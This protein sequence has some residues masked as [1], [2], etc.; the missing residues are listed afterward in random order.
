MARTKQIT[1]TLLAVWLALGGSAAFAGEISTGEAEELV[2]A[3]QSEALVIV[4]DP[5]LSVEESKQ[6]FQGIVERYFD[7]PWMVRFLLGRY[8]RVATA[9]QRAEF[10]RL[11]QAL[12]VDSY[13]RNLVGSAT[14]FSVQVIGSRL[15]ANGRRAVVTTE[16]LD[17]ETDSTLI[18]WVVSKRGNTDPR[19]I[20][21]VFAGISFLA[22]KREEFRT[23]MR[24]HGGNI[25]AVLDELRAQVA[26]L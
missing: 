18:Q 25:E 12:T 16:I 4:S 26:R 3:M 11:Y 24:R 10:A 1:K 14:A 22:T 8:R 13:S 15:Q 2:S 17:S 5:E 9:E 6:R 21:V 23:A 7:V 19:I 20:D